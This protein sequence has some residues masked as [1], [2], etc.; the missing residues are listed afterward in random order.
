MCGGGGE[1]E[2]MT[3]KIGAG[4]PALGIV[5]STEGGMCNGICG[6]VFQLLV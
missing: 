6:V 2:S 1:R 3:R 4:V 5:K